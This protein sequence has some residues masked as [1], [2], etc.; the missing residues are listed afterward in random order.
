MT[1][2]AISYIISKDQNALFI[3]KRN[4]KRYARVSLPQWNLFDKKYSFSLQI[5]QDP[6]NRR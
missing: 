2:D 1:F 4:N 3:H 5:T 6:Q